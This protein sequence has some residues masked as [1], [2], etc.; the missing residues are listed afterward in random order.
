[1][2]EAALREVAN[3]LAPK[4]RSYLLGTSNG[5]DLSATEKAALDK[6]KNNPT[7][8]LSNVDFIVNQIENDIVRPASTTTTTTV[9]SQQQTATT[10]PPTRFVPSTRV[11]G[12]GSARGANTP[13]ATAAAPTG[14]TPP[15]QSSQ[16]PAQTVTSG[17]GRVPDEIS[18]ILF[19]VMQDKYYKALESG[20]TRGL[21]KDEVLV[22]NWLRSNYGTFNFES[23]AFLAMLKPLGDMGVAEIGAELN[24]RQKEIPPFG[25]PEYGEY[26]REKNKVAMTAP[27]TPTP[28]PSTTTTTT[29]PPANGTTTTTQPPSGSRQPPADPLGRDTGTTGFG[30]GDGRAPSTA[31][32]GRVTPGAGFGPER[33]GPNATNQPPMGSRTNTGPT[34]PTGATGPTG[35]T[36]PGGPGGGGGVFTAPGAEPAAVP[37]D[38]EDAAAQMYPEFY[39]IMD[40][41]PEI[42]ALLRKAMGPPAYDEARFRAELMATNWWKTTEASAREWDLASG[43]DPASYQARV[44]ERAG[45]INVEALNLGIRLSPEKLQEL[46][47]TSLRL[48]YDPVKIT[49][50]IGMAAVAG[51]S[52][53]ATQLRTGF[54]GQA[55]RET[56]AQYGVRL[57]D[58][59][60]NSFVN[61]MAVG[62]ETIGS[63]QDYVMEIGKSLF[64]SLAPQFDSGRTFDQI[65]GSYKTYAAEI[66]ERDAN[67]IDMTDPLFAQAVTYQ[68]D[69]KTG[70]QRLMN[71]QEWGDYLRNTESFGYQFTEGAKSRAYAVADQIANM[72]GR[73]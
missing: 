68:P 35:P 27:G 40:N 61:R 28:P 6:V 53:G 19:S 48:S 56:A 41:N 66:L 32:S 38:W 16:A 64:P 3:R 5:R 9:P 73:I 72:F 12:Q 71:L 26:W 67:S 30:R 10:L 18:W 52:E 24:T 17:F 25:T 22:L 2:N 65:T 34:G 43:L 14:T 60:F 29:Q 8:G 4:Y 7:L 47:L 23:P 20:S 1:M 44:D 62:E 37:T 46:A 59:T 63:F 15:S 11:P 31:S 69:P 13:A 49:N 45:Q 21:S 39:A 70:E 42:A 58:T 36:G 55:I 50:S 51:G 57:S 54:Y 33:G